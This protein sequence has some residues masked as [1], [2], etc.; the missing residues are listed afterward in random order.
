MWEISNLTFSYLIWNNAFSIGLEQILWLIFFLYFFFPRSED[1]QDEIYA[2]KGKSLIYM[3]SSWWKNN[4]FDK[5][6]EAYVD[7]KV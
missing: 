4:D 1:E 5:I 6:F 2:H 7:F 3:I